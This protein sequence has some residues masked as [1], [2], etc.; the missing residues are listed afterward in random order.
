MIRT[1]ETEALEYLLDDMDAARRAVFEDNLTCYP[2]ARVA[3]EE[4]SD[5]LA[6]LRRQALEVPF[7]GGVV[8]MEIDRV[9]EISATTAKQ[10]LFR[11]MNKLRQFAALS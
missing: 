1:F 3:L 10:T 4:F 9:L 7:I 8:D 6:T 2:A 11:S 5:S